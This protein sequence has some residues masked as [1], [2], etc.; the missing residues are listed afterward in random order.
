M[1]IS[2]LAQS[3][4]IEKAKAMVP[5]EVMPVVEQVVAAV[6]GAKKKEAPAPPPAK[7]TTGEGTPT[8]RPAWVMPVVIGTASVGLLGF[9]GWLLLRKKGA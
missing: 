9:A 6:K 1:Y 4:L 3:D 5:K 2:E 7:L 8:G